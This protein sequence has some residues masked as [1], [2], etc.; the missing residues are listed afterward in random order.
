MLDNLVT[1]DDIK[2]SLVLDVDDTYYDTM[3]TMYLLSAVEV[4]NDYVK[5]KEDKDI[6]QNIAKVCIIAI[7]T[8]LWE[9]RG[10]TARESLRT[11][12]AVQTLLLSLEH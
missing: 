12:V 4:L 8:D 11:N 2:L 5:D 10:L 9:N 3:L 6:K 1:L 7:V